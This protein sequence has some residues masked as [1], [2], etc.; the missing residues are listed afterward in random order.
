M[1]Q[2]VIL[3]GGAGT[4]MGGVVKALLQ[5]EKQ[6]FLQRLLAY[7]NGWG[8]SNIV[9]LCGDYPVPDGITT[10]R[11]GTVRR[12]T[13]GAVLNALP[14][15]VDPFMVVNGDSLVPRLD[16][17]EVIRAYK[18]SKKAGLMVAYARQWPHEDG[19]GERPN[20]QVLGGMVEDYSK[21]HHAK[22]MHHVDAG[23][24]ITNP[25]EFSQY[26]GG[27]EPPFDLGLVYRGMIRAN[28]LAA[29][30]TKQV[31]FEVGSP[32]GLERYRAAV[33]AGLA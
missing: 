13:G 15:L 3:A 4:R 21:E 26:A 22:T 16:F 31:P 33:K 27:A 11:E 23:V 8:I 28:Q 18:D 2:T 24:F 6:P 10:V 1:I 32:E 5:V 20:T 19:D 17:R 7:Y 29:Y 9:L 30:E 14:K 12:G 25:Y